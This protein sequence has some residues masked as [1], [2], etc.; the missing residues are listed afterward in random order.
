M[1]P[2]VKI[3]GL[4]RMEDVELCIRLGTDILGFVVEYPRPVPWNISAQAAKGLIDAARGR[5]ETCIVTGGAPERVLSLALETGTDYVQLHCD[6]TPADAAFLVKTL[7][8]RARVVK[9]LYPDTNDLIK[10]ALAFDAAG[11]Y[12][13]LL[14]PRIPS[15]ASDGGL[16]DLSA[17]KELRDAVSCPVILAGGISPY[18]AADMVRQS[19]A[20][21]IDL[22]SG[23]ESSPG[24]KDAA[25]V[26]ALF[27]ALE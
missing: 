13:L 17:W 22:M 25:Q 2:V 26:E 10:T 4:T 11:V 6:E 21:F 19:G 24:I 23:V 5:A 7:N 20:R 12:A 14:D 9:A 15:R 3:C 1:R 8:K 16:A 27:R 18:N